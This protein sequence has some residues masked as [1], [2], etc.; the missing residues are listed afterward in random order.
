MFDFDGTI[1][2][3][4]EGMVK[5]LVE[6]LHKHGFDIDPAI[7]PQYIGPPIRHMLRQHFGLQDD[8]LIETITHDYRQLYYDY[9]ADLSHPYQGIPELL[10]TLHSHGKKLA[11][12]SLK[13]K[14][15]LDYL[16]KSY[17]LDHLFAAVCGPTMQGVPNTKAEVIDMA[18][19]M[20][21]SQAPIMIGDTK[22]DIDGA[23]QRQ[24]PC[25]AV[26]YGFGKWDDLQHANH[27]VP[28]VQKLGELLLGL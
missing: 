7:I 19:Q 12:A 23:H 10:H 16:L 6:A 13:P 3:T 18:C 9:G 26:G 21:A 22:V 4:E 20:V 17:Q 24:I 2:N 8:K 15:V 28:T 11:V 1:S 14:P 5:S 27:V 25:I